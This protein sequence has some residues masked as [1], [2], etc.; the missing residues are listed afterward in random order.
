VITPGEWNVLANPR[1][2]DEAK[3][4]DLAVEFV[5]DLRDSASVVASALQFVGSRPSHSV[6]SG[7]RRGSVRAASCD[8]VGDPLPLEAGIHTDDDHPEVHQVGDD[9]EECGF[10]TAMLGASGSEGTADL[11]VEGTVHP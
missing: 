6:T 9:A 10:L 2:H 11:P 4:R 3:K 8:F 7:D 5:R 1:G